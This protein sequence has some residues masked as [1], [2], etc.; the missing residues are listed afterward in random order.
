[1]ALLREYEYI[2]LV[3]ICIYNSGQT[4][5][6]LLIE[7]IIYGILS[8]REFSLYQN[9]IYIFL[10][11]LLMMKVVVFI[12]LEIFFRMNKLNLVWELSLLLI[13]NHFLSNQNE[14]IFTPA[15]Q[16]SNRRAHV[17]ILLA[18]HVD[19]KIHHF[20]ENR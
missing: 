16:C 1:M 17:S 14:N 8:F 15:L 13:R 6:I 3:Y 11:H 9:W 7:S 19:G 18:L 2:E 4:M 5:Y 20:T 12:W 10:V